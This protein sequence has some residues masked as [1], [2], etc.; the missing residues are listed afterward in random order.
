MDKEST[1]KRKLL[2]TGAVIALFAGTSAASAQMGG[3]S[4]QRPGMNSPSSGGSRGDEQMKSGVHEKEPGAAVQNDKGTDKKG[5]TAQNEPR[6]GTAQ[7]NQGESK[8]KLGKGDSKE[9]MGEK[10]E[11]KEK[12]GK[13]ESKERMG[14]KSESKEKLG[15][16]ES[17]ER[18]GEKSE[19]KEKIG[20]T[21]E[22][23]TRSS[24]GTSSA[25]AVQLSSEQRSRI[26]TT[27]KT[28][29][30]SQHVEPIRN[31]NFEIRVGVRVPRT[32]HLYTLP[33]E[34]VEIVPEYR[35]FEYVLVG[36]EILIIDPNTLEIV[37]VLPA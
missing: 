9:K 6:S 2:M 4:D 18:M 14:E 1:M 27:I 5:T 3:T 17:K 36:D 30:R 7:M 19:S 12:L 21:G 8:E 13:G 20:Q 25:K 23:T 24:Q 33:T 35:G 11:S 37:A 22:S 10:S 26:S 16:G 28:T 29:I 32:V 31:V 15:K 34:I